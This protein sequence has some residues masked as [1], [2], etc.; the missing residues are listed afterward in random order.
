MSGASAT[1]R[2]HL[3]DLLEQARARVETMSPD[4]MEAMLRAQ[5][6]SWV[7]GEMAMGESSAM[8]RAPA[9]PITAATLAGSLD[10]LDPD[11]ALITPEAMACALARSNRWAGNTMLPVSVAQHSVLVMEIFIRRNPVLRHAAISPLLHDGHE[12]AIGDL[13]VP[14]VKLLTLRLPGLDKHIEAEKLRLDI[15][16]R[17]AWGIPAPGIDILALVHEADR[18]AA[19][20]EWLSAIHPTN[21]Q[22]PFPA[23]PAGIPR[24]IKPLSWDRAEDAF[25]QALER[26]LALR[27]WEAVGEG[28]G[29]RALGSSMQDATRSRRPI[30]SDLN[31]YA[32]LCH[33]ANMKWWQDETGKPLERNKGELL[34]LIHSEISEAMEGERKGLRD[35]KLPHRW[36]AE[37]ELVD[38]MIRIFD[39][40]AAFG[41]DLQG[42]F[43]EKMAFNAVREDHKH[44]ARSI[45]G[46]KK[47]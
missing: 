9:E 10:L 16:I 8:H 3:D 37:V 32:N 45:A 20:I 12:Y 1:S 4:E 38:A 33:A 34:C 18:F 26:E 31:D 46:G 39:Y 13:S 2:P 29:L 17:A 30:M 36:M 42:A 27:P 24:R 44:E 41:Y 7:R 19:S 35:D 6:R 11:P 15:A 5:Q 28:E 21:G 23:P 43:E 22:N 25:R 14:T 40:A 47:W